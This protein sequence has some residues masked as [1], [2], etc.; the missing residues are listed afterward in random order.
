[1]QRIGDHSRI[2]SFLTGSSLTTFFSLVNFIVFS[3]VLAYYNWIIFA[4]FVTGNSLYVIWIMFF[5]KFRR[6]LD[7]KRFAQAA[8]EQSNLYQLITG[9]QDIKLNNS[10]DQKRWKWKQ[11]Q[12]KLFR[13]SLQSLKVEQYQKLGSAFFNQTTNILITFIAAR[14]VVSGNMT[15]GMMMSVTYIVGQLNAP[16]EQF[17]SFAR[18]FQDARISLERLNE[19][20]QQKDEEQDISTKSENLPV[21]QTIH[22][23]HLYFSYSG[24]DEDTV[25][26]DINLTSRKKDNSNCRNKR[27]WKNNVDQ[28]FTRILFSS[29]RE[30]SNR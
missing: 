19:I 17:I 18:A 7:V 8:G 25:L 11:I 24:H 22:I 28:T 4:L 23:N 15:L 27:K 1:M 6:E 5:M 16:I 12:I 29:K 21:D 20:H 3:I 9:M 30:H 14:A 10:E 13:I 26:S 2:E